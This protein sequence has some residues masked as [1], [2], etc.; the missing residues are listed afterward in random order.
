MNNNSYVDNSEI[1]GSLVKSIQSAIALIGIILNTLAI[2]VFERKELKKH[3]YSI[4]WKTKALI[5]S[6]VLL[7]I[8]RVFAKHFLN[9]DLNLISPIFCHLVNYFGYVT[10]GISLW[11]E[12]IITFDRFFII[13]YPNRFG[14]MRKRSFQIAAILFV[15]VYSLIIYSNYPINIRLDKVVDLNNGTSSESEKCHISVNIVKSMWIIS[16]VNTFIVNIVVNPILDLIIISRIISTRRNARHLNRWT[17]NDRKFAVSAIG[18]NIN[19]LILKFPFFLVN[20]LVKKFAVNIEQTEMVYSITLCVSLI[21]K[22]DVL[23]LNLL[24][25]SI[26]RREFLSMF[27][28]HK[29]SRAND[30]ASRH[31][32]L[33]KTRAT[34]ELIPR[35]PLC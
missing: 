1:G 8:F 5:E 15:V 2:C 7:Y 16:L 25:N 23:L 4:Y 34:F 9:A 33:L 10:F 20:L 3:S 31:E 12:C 30:F 13:V 19:S 32:S 14:F 35:P 11:L 24:V 6:L 27:G 17:I 18:L 21:D 26:F 29:K 28:F 22:V